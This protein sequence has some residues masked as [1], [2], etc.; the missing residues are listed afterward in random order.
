VEGDLAGLD[1]PVLDVHLVAHHHDRH[2][3]HHP[4]QIFVPLGDALVGDSGGDVEHEDGGVGPN[5][6]P[7]A[8]AAQLLLPGRVPKVQPDRAVRRVEGEG[9]DLD[10]LGRDV[11][12]LELAGDVTLEEGGLPHAAVA[13]QHHLELHCRLDLGS[14]FGGMDL[15]VGLK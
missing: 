5:V 8:Q 1:L 4:R 2:V 6:V 3:L 11:S 15:G 10:A 14:G 13:D 9:T 12:L 7:L